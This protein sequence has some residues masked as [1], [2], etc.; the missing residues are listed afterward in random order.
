MVGLSGTFGDEADSAL[1]E[2]VPPTVD[3][4]VTTSY[5]DDGVAVEGAFHAGT[6]TEQ[7]AETA[8]GALVWIW[9]EVFSVTDS[10][11]NTTGGDTTSE[12]A[13]RS[14]DP[15]ESAVVCARQYDAHGLEFVERL[16]GE[17]VGC[18]YDPNAGSVSFFLDR[19]G[20]RPLYYALGDDGIAFSTNVQTVPDLPGVDLR[21]DESFLAE[22]LYCRRTLG[23]ETPIEGIQQLP[24]ATVATVDLDDWS[25]EQRRYWEPRFRPKDEPISYFVDELAE[26]FERAV[27]DRTS[28][29]RDCGLLLSG[30]S[31]SRAVLAAA[32]GPIQTLHLGDGW[33]REATIAKRVADAADAPF[34]LLERGAAYHAKLLDRAAPIAEFV[35]PFHTGHALGFAEEIR[36]DV[37]VLLTGLYS[38]DCFGGWSVSQPT[39]SLPGGVE[40]TVPVARLPATTQAFVDEQVASGPTR[41]PSWLDAAPLGEI[42]SANVATDGEAV[43]YHGVAYESVEQLSL[44]DTLVPITNGIGFD[45]YS[46]LQIAPTRNPFLDRRLLDLHC[47]LP[48]NYRVRDDVLHR[49]LGRLDRSLAAIP[50]ASTRLPL[51]Y[52]HAAHVVGN[53]VVNQLDKLGRASYRTEGPWQN[54][55]EVIRHDDFLGEAITTHE[56]T[57]R[58]LPGIDYESVQRSYRRHRDREIDVAEELYRLATVLSMPLTQRVVDGDDSDSD[59]GTRNEVVRSGDVDRASDDG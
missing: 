53:R 11:A 26:R 23:T 30:G 18:I 28:D 56:E 41:D 55:N 7:P 9:G 8:D 44:D 4:E 15:N 49:A 17:F 34:E 57:I 27:R 32:D 24:P 33:N 31:D 59:E 12:P 5:S 36:E 42:L 20:A 6:A 40:L 25:I 54:K 37:D 19:V 13:R 29:D 2:T 22:Y 51:T 16:D 46:A 10:S 47:E 1:V 39:M 21:F 58:A 52:P 50:H 45:L 14:V 48:L 3:R 43:E 38:D 35:G